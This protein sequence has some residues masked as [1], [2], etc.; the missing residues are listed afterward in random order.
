MIEIEPTQRFS[1]VDDGD[2][3]QIKFWIGVSESEFRPR[4]SVMFDEWR[5][6][7]EKGLGQIVSLLGDDRNC[8]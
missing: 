7:P 2:C 3:A 6:S 5:L 8:S 1:I 4:C